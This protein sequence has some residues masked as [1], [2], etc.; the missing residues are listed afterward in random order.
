M[1]TQFRELVAKYLAGILSEE[2]KGILAI[3]LKVPENQLYLASKIDEQFY[4]QSLKEIGDDET[5]S[6]IFQVIQQKLTRDKSAHI[7]P[8]IGEPEAKVV[9]IAWYK[10]AIFRWTA[11]AAA[12]ILVIL[13]WNGKLFIDNPDEQSVVAQNTN[14]R[15]DSVS[16]IVRRETNTTGKEKRIQL[17][18]GSLIV[19]ADKS[20]IAY[21]EPFIDKRDITLKGKAYFKVAKDEAKPFRVISG[22][23]STTAL[24]TEFTVTAFEKSTQII[25]RLY[26]GKVVV[27]SVKQGNKKLKSDIY[28]KPG[29]EFV[30]GHQNVA[31]VKE[32]KLNADAVPEKIISQELSRDDLLIPENIEG[33]WYMFN[34]QSLA[35]VFDQLA[36]MYQVEI[37]YNKQEVQDLYFIGKYKRSDSIENILKEIATLNSLKVTRQDNVFS[38]IK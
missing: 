34:N 36:E 11:A 19:L 4:D 31:E 17:S 21:H 26:E 32:F 22:D 7:T 14:N 37:V 9:N 16:H 3:L 25:V 33:S 23:I 35:Q 10:T 6:Q 15:T 1:D 13:W 20:E 30:Y 29:E 2:E 27:K 8:E 28:L 12:C 24:G 5:K 38:I 18:D